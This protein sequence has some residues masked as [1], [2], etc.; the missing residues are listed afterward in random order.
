MNESSSIQDSFDI[1]DGTIATSPNLVNNGPKGWLL[2]FDCV[3]SLF[4][5]AANILLIN[6]VGNI[7][8]DLKSYRLFLINLW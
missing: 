6:A 5:I 3:V 4:A 8:L 1:L 7:K 2:V